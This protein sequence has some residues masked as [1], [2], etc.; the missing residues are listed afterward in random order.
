MG[1][2]WPY[3]STRRL[4][5]IRMLEIVN[6]KR[7]KP[8]PILFTRVVARDLYTLIIDGRTTVTPEVANYESALRTMP[9]IESI[10]PRGGSMQSRGGTT[11]FTY[12]IKFKPEAL[13][14][15]VP[16]S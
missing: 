2:R 16:P 9:Q 5:P 13:R 10:E 14:A 1:W 6:E 3:V 7:S 8:S 12:T 11:T 15:A 4:L